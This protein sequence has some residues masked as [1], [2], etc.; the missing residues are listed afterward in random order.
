MKHIIFMELFHG[1]QLLNC[2]SG[3]YK[4]GFSGK[5]GLKSS[6]YYPEEGI[7]TLIWSAVLLQKWLK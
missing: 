3:A 4:C 7:I 1:L 2:L 5:T 6:S